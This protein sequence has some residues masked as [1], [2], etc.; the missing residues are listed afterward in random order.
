MIPSAALADAQVRHEGYIARMVLM[1]CLL[2]VAIISWRIATVESTKG[3]QM[4]CF[5][6][7]V[8]AYY[9]TVLFD[10]SL[11]RWKCWMRS[12]LE[13]SA[14]SVIMIL[15]AQTGADYLVTSSTSYLYMLAVVITC[16]RLDTTLS[17]YTSFLAIAQQLGVYAYAFL[18]SGE[19]HYSGPGFSTQRLLQE[20]VF[21]LG[22]LGVA[23]L[24]GFL[25]TRTL[26][27]EI[28]KAGEDARVRSA[29]GSYVDERV[30]K[31]VL[32]GDLKIAPERRPITVMFV[33]I[34]DFTRLAETSDPAQLF[35]MLNEVLDA[36]AVAVQRQGGLVNKFLG[37][38]LMAIFGAPEAQTDH[39]R[40]A[41]RA[42]LMIEEAALL[43][44]TD[45]RFPG[46]SIG[47][48]IHTGETIVGDIGGARREYTAIGDVVNVAARV[49]AANKELGTTILVTQAVADAIGNDVDL[50]PTRAVTLRGRSAPIELFEVSA[51]SVNLE[52]SGELRVLGA[53]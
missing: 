23:G 9:G 32:K 8:S 40:R 43:R 3:F 29:F 33:D 39:C 34:R 16:L 49:E 10:Q 6:L 52:L 12:T 1:T 30:V 53:S 31:R 48:G 38:G 44:R 11:P 17:I 35:Q 21:R 14:A 7:V 4:L 13:V 5:A 51:M 27:R 26:K 25:L 37:D 15:D 46:L 19:L 36:F 45:G 20:L 24:L 50:R 47:I 2:G 22:A 42:A 18:A 41:V 28:E